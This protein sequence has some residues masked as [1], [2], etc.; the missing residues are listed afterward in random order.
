MGRWYAMAPGG[1]RGCIHIARAWNRYAGKAYFGGI[2]SFSAPDFRRINGFP[3]NFWGWGG[4]DD[5]L[6][7]RVQDTR[8]HVTKPTSGGTITD[9]EK[10]SLNDKMSFLR[11]HREWKN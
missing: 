10:M 1:T 2:N 6:R 7:E 11:Q 4:E 9:L 3:N 8:V 5:E